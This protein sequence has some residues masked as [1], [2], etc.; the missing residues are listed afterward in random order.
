MS[1]QFFEI[2]FVHLQSQLI[3]IVG[4]DYISPISD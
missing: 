4:H 1:I 3:E 2:D